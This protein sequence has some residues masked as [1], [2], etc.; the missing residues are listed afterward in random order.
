MIDTGPLVATLNINDAHHAWTV[1]QLKELRG[2]M[3]TC[4]AVLSEAFFLLKTVQGGSEGLWRMLDK[5]GVKIDFALSTQ[6]PTVSQFMHKY[7]DVPMSLA[8]AC[9]VRMSELRPEHKV[10]TLDHHFTIY[11][12]HRNR[13]IPVIVPF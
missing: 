7:A 3:L 6:M 10:L 9:L 4:E 13:R 5:G 1:A 2:P 12:R 8:D 11:R